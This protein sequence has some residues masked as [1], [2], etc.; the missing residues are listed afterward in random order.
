MGLTVSLS[1]VC[2]MRVRVR[3]LVAGAALLAGVAAVAL[4][5]GCSS[6]A[7]PGPATVRGRV[8][9]QGYPMASA[10]V[11]FAPD[12]ERGTGGKPAR[13]ETGP[14]GTFHLRLD[15]A[16]DIPPGWYRVA[17][18]APRVP[19][20]QSDPLI[21][22]FPPQLARP[23]RSG[24]VREVTPGKDHVFEFAVQVPNPPAQ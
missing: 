13:G 10:L 14:D 17:L 15:G 12:P 21:P 3:L 4:P 7:P 20:A 24:I 18:A 22:P 11:V 9:F 2:A 1:G 5:G 23:D 16:T 6:S 8:T 19:S